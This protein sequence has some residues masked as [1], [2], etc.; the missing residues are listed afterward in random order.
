MLRP[1]LRIELLPS[2]IY[3]FRHGESEGNVL[4]KEDK[5]IQDKPNHRFEL[6]PLGAW[7]PL[8]LRSYIRDKRILSR[9]SAA[10]I[11]TFLRSQ[12]TLEIALS[13]DDVSI[14]IFEDSRLDEWWKG[15]FHSLSEEQIDKHYS[16][17]REVLKRERWH[18][19]RPPQG[20]SGKDVEARLLSFF[21]ELRENS[22]ISGHGRAY[23]FTKRLLCNEPLDLDCNYPNIANCE[24]VLFEKKGD[25]YLART[26]FKP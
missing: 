2:E 8:E 21:K 11:S 19:Y 5:S 18:H 17:E 13:Q 20:E 14:P 6:T 1:N 3:I 12:R 22:L 9:C 25:R 15:I 23:G 4:S 16:L 7:K 26:L 24:L 10:Y